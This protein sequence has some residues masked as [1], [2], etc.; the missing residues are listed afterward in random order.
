MFKWTT[1]R[2]ALLP[3]H[4][5]DGQADEVHGEGAETEQHDGHRGGEGRQ[6]ARAQVYFPDPDEV[7]QV[8]SLGVK[9]LAR[10]GGSWHPPRFKDCS[11]RRRPVSCI[12]WRKCRR[13]VL[14]ALASRVT[15]TGTGVSGWSVVQARSPAWCWPTAAPSSWGCTGSPAGPS[16]HPPRPANM[17]G[18]QTFGRYTIDLQWSVLFPYWGKWFKKAK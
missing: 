15:G 10:W 17:I 18:I 2:F 16:L 7:G 9:T 11:G 4:H 8:Q 14:L 3:L 13:L 6:G 1:S 12:S 5:P